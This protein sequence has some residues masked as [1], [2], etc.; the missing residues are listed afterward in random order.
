M[1]LSKEINV[2]NQRILWDELSEVLGENDL[3]EEIS[4]S[5]VNFE[6][7]LNKAQKSYMWGEVR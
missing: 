4:A 3:Y 5:K 2:Q 6:T 7:W 1:A